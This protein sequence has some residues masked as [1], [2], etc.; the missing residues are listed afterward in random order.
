MV[1]QILQLYFNTV[2]LYSVSELPLKWQFPTL[3]DCWSSFVYIKYMHIAYC[4]EI[5]F[6]VTS[7]TPT[8]HFAILI[9]CIK[10]PLCSFGGE[11]QTLTFDIYNIN[12]VIIQTQI[13]FFPL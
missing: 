13:F 8:M 10:G 12:E 11:I 7:N 5:H 2:L 9:R 6:L 3:S 1:M 4:I